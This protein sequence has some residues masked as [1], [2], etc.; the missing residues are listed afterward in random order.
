[1]DWEDIKKRPIIGS[2]RRISVLFGS[3]EYSLETHRANGLT[4][5][6][7]NYGFLYC[8]VYFFLVFQSFESLGHWGNGSDRSHAIGIFGIVLLW[9]ISFSEPIFDRLLLKS[10]IFLFPIYNQTKYQIHQHNSKY[11]SV[12]GNK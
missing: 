7:R 4:V 2:S 9:V 10:L 12:V 5:F 11:I 3:Q 1:M 6:V 8:L